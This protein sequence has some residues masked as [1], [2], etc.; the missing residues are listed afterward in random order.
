MGVTIEGEDARTFGQ[1]V[2]DGEFDDVLGEAAEA[3]A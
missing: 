1:R 3:S 2:D